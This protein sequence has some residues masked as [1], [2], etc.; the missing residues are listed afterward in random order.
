M[1]MVIIALTFNASSGF[2]I[3]IP[4]WIF[5]DYK[6]ETDD[7]NYTEGKRNVENLMYFLSCIVMALTIPPL[8]FFKSSPP[9]PPSYTASDV[10]YIFKI[11]KAM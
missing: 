4:Y 11:I 1:I 3:R 8:L 2:S 10:R 5:G 6:T 7:I 9:T